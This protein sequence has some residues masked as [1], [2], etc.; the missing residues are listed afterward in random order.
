MGEKTS[1]LVYSLPCFEP[2]LINFNFSLPRASESD[3]RRLTSIYRS[4]CC[5]YSTLIMFGQVDSQ[6]TIR[7]NMRLKSRSKLAGSS[8]YSLSSLDGSSSLCRIHAHSYTTFQL[9][10]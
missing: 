1:W 7:K 5:P 3:T 10:S 9:D 4:I 2:A 6:A 8:P